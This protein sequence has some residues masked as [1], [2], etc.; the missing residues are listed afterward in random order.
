VNTIQAGQAGNERPITS[1][2]EE[3]FSKD[4]KITLLYTNDDPRFA[5]TVNKVVNIHAGN[6]DPAVFHIP[7]GY[8]VKDVYCRDG[9]CKY[10]SE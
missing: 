3:W 1:V 5:V 7:E 4:L 6:P 9:V 8:T 2:T 10:D